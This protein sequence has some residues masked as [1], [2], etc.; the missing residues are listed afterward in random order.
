MYRE[1]CDATRFSELR[2]SHTVAQITTP[3]R[4]RFQRHWH[5][6]CRDHRAENF[7][8]QFFI[9][10]QRG[11][12]QPVAHFFRGATHVDVDDLRA[13]IDVSACGFGESLGIRARELHGA[14]LRFAR[15]IH[16][17]LRFFRRPQTDVTGDH[18]RRREARAELPCDL[19]EWTISYARHGG[20]HDIR[21]EGV[22]TNLHGLS[23]RCGVA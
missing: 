13:E 12:T 17:T 18:F 3:S 9:S 4:A 15:V 14:R 23:R 19:S 8:N 20:E 2:D 10:E 1:R 22:R 16:A 7:T 6:G 21:V 5:A 11:T